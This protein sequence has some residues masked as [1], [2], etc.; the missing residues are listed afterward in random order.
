MLILYCLALCQHSTDR[1]WMM[2][3]V[4]IAVLW[5]GKSKGLNFD[6]DCFVAFPKTC[7][8]LVSSSS[9][10]SNIT[11]EDCSA[12][13]EELH[14]ISSTTCIRH[15]SMKTFWT[16]KTSCW[17]H[18]KHPHVQF[19][20]GGQ[21]VQAG[22]LGCR[23]KRCRYSEMA[24]QCLQRKARTIAKSSVECVRIR[25]FVNGPT[26]SAT[27]DTNSKRTAI[28]ASSTLISFPRRVPAVAFSKPSS[29]T[30]CCCRAILEIRN[31]QASSASYRSEAKPV[32]GMALM[33]KQK[34]WVN[35]AEAHLNVPCYFMRMISNLL[36]HPG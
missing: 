24:S 7:V 32:S 35:C 13:S 33:T 6:L 9:Y 19:L 5:I 4:Q 12:R 27:V 36:I 29:C 11:S 10:R 28:K 1:E 23:K 17:A 2:W 26:N 22:H 25:V 3:K 31:W 15:F 8:Y 34:H 18:V 20:Y 16:A 30:T 14:L 21:T